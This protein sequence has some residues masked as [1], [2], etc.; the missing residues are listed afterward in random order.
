MV[1]GIN[2]DSGLGIINRP[3]DNLGIQRNRCN[4]LSVRAPLEASD[5]CGVI[6]PVGD[7]EL[8]GGLDCV[9]ERARERE[10]TA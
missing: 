10:F 2:G 8:K 9:K 1:S 5:S 7:F 4:V 6:Y 3:H